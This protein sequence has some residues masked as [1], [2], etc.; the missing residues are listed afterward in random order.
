MRTAIRDQRSGLSFQA[1]C[2]LPISDCRKLN[3]MSHR[4][5]AC[6]LAFLL[7]AAASGALM[8]QEQERHEQKYQDEQRAELEAY[9]DRLIAASYARRAA[10]WQRDFSGI[11]AYLRSIAPW[12]DRFR[13]YLGGLDYKP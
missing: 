2:W 5:A 4:T 3:L 6:L 12:R 11:G 1:G 9:Y 13:A 7:T 8:A 10:A